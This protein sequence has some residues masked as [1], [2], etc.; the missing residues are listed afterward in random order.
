MNR[1]AAFGT[2]IREHRVDQ[3][4]SQEHLAQKAGFHRNFVSLVERGERSPTLENA[5]ALAAA[6]DLRLSTLVRDVER[7]I[8][9]S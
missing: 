3:G 5:F 6:L 7:L 9:P 4:L 2:L 8:D 1:T